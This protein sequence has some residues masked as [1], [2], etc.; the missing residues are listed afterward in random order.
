MAACPR[1]AAFN[2]SGK[3]QPPPRHK[4]HS[5]QQTDGAVDTVWP[6]VP[7]RHWARS[8]TPR[9]PGVVAT[10]GQSLQP[11]SGTDGPLPG[12]GGDL[13][14]G[15]WPAPGPEQTPRP[16]TPMSSDADCATIRG[17]GGDTDPGLRRQTGQTPPQGLHPVAPSRKAARTG[18]R[19]GDTGEA[20]HVPRT[21]PWPVLTVAS[22]PAGGPACT[23]WTVTWL[24][25]GSPPSAGICCDDAVGGSGAP[26]PWNDACGH[27]NDRTWT[28]RP[29]GNV[30]RPSTS[31]TPSPRLGDLR[32]HLG[33]Q[34]C[35]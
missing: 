11:P 34:D 1:P 33:P 26:G 10:P 16:L 20:M 15:G 5:E 9:G 12:R 32:A 29:S 24:I 8:L 18:L 21:C 17:L 23:R 4:P 19:R 6:P 3:P 25:S 30:G 27:Q 28:A 14:V 7:S 13:L 22:E 2:P 35:T 31:H